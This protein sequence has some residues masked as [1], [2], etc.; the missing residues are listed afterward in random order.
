MVTTSVNRRVE[1]TDFIQ[2]YYEDIQD[3]IDEFLETERL[4]EWYAKQI[5]NYWKNTHDWWDNLCIIRGSLVP[6]ELIDV[7]SDCVIGY[8]VNI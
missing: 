5:E 2:E 3:Q 6:E 8:S 1:T 7:T 4:S